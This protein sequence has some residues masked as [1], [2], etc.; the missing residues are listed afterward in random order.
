MSFPITVT[1]F[2]DNQGSNN[3]REITLHKGLT[4][5][6]GPN[7]SGKTHLLRS[8]KNSL[9]PHVENKKIRFLSAG[10]M[11]PLEHYRSDNDGYGGS[12]H[13]DGAR[14]GSSSETDRRHSIET[15][16]GDFQ[17][18][19]QRADILI[20]IQERLRKLFNKDIMLDWDSS[21]LKASFINL[22]SPDSQYSSGKEAS[23]LIHLVGILSALYD[24]EVGALLIDEP[25]VSLHPQL[26]SFLL[27][28][29]INA[30]GHPNEGGYKKI[31][32]IAT[33]STEMF[34]INKPSDLPSIVFCH[35]ISK[36]PVQIPTDAGELSSR[37]V[38]ELIARLG[39]EHKLSLFSKRP[40]LVE[41]PSDTF[42]CSALSNAF[43]IHLE[44]AGS[45]LLPVIGKGRMPIVAKLFRLMGKTPI[46]LVDADGIADGTELINNYLAGNLYADSL[47]STS[48]AA[49][50]MSMATSIYSDFC[51][52][53]TNE[54]D[55][56]SSLAEQHPYWIN[57]EQTEESNDIKAKRRSTFCILFTYDN[58]RLDPIFH[59]I[60]NRLIALLD[61][62]EKCGLFILKKG[63]IE[64][65][66]LTSDQSASIGK[67]NAAIEEIEAFGDIS[68]S[69]LK[70]SYSDVVRCIRHAA[71]TQQINEAEALRT[72]IL[73]IVSPAHE[74]FKY[75]RTSTNF[76]SI[77][78]TI[79]RER[80]DIFDLTVQDDMLVVSIKSAILN[81]ANFPVRLSR[82]DN[83]PSII[84]RA[85]G[86]NS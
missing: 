74:E 39:Q 27:Q 67:P 70:A 48:G 40:L 84:N 35:D 21:G 12:P 20:K 62:L 13:F 68:P 66:Y 15:L 2:I 63:S 86:I 59:P 14:L 19:S 78:R 31:I 10:R 45:Q 42:I 11:S 47:A 73:S 6:I 34:K 3:S 44:A 4:T 30:S 69:D 16:K 17:T 80:A 56:I 83:V 5:L 65:Y 24:D 79:L 8:L 55:R 51:D 60:K 28:E 43:N 75:D 26:Q 1:T 9:F 22:D 18:L 58:T 29:I 64:S 77:A 76:N 81:V 54:W 72:L 37:K 46:A 23:G 32:V 85:L 61:I 7:G 36:S 71:M 50:A 33:H 57:R 53:V 25:E 52:I 38:K 49:T 41:G 82:T